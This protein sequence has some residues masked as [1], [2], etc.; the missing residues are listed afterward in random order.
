MCVCSIVPCSIGTVIS[1]YLP[2]FPPGFRLLVDSPVSLRFSPTVQVVSQ[3]QMALWAHGLDHGIVV[4]IG[5]Q[6]TI[7]VPVVR[8][9]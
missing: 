4:N 5:Q 2:I 8:G 6:Q 3:A 9:R 1:N 7:A